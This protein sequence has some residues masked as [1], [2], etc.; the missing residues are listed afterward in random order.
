MSAERAA[1]DDVLIII[2]TGAM[3]LSVARRMGSGRVIVL[4]DIDEG[5]LTHV[6]EGLITDGHRVLTKT[7]DVTSRESV[8]ALAAF[9]ADA[10]RV[11]HLV[12]T[13]GL[14]PSQA[15]AEAILA[16]DLLGVALVLDEF[17]QVIAP[18]GSA[19][20]IASMSAHIFPA[21]DAAVEAQLAT[22]PADDLLSL[23]ACVEAA[24]TGAF[25]YP[26]AK[27]AN[28]IR[29]A[30][31]AKSWGRRGA[32]INSISP[33]IISTAM[34]RLELDSENGQAM[35]DMVKSSGSGRLGTP[36]DIGAATELLL[37]PLASFITGIDL[38]VD[39]GV[40][41]AMRTGGFEAADD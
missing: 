18:G 32:R 40:M 20:V 12:H 29:V 25:A 7:V 14:S 26:F 1:K 21:P 39:G 6:A 15:S 13:A 38:L 10:G 9:A 28:V 23:P 33:G 24:T 2:G 36:D 37:G 34:G 31:A 30:A 3:G 35:R 19:V 4:A 22:T 16:V 27:R 8:A 11:L 5:L 41:A 17:G